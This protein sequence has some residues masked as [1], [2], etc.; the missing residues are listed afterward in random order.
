MKA[1][2]I[3]LSS[4]FV[5][6]A[7]GCSSADRNR[8][9]G[10]REAWSASNTTGGSAQAGGRDF[11]AVRAEERVVNAQN[12]M[13]AQKFLSAKGFNPGT[14]SGQVTEQTRA[15]IRDYQRHN[16]F[17]VT[18]L[19]DS[20]TL[21]SMERQGAGFTGTLARQLERADGDPTQ[22]ED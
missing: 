22:G 14:Q 1:K 18:G 7:M 21:I 19:L 8:A 9:S 5:I 3:V 4:L 11:A 6:G 15:A 13:E 10:T 12:W 17:N 20:Q 16:R 2:A